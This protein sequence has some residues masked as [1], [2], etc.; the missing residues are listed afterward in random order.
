M[1]HIEVES[2]DKCITTC[3]PW[4]YKINFIFFGEKNLCQ[5]KEK[6]L[7]IKGGTKNGRKKNGKT[8]PAG[9]MIVLAAPGGKCRNWKQQRRGW[10]KKR[11]GRKFSLLDSFLSLPNVLSLYYYY[12]YY[13]RSSI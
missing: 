3:G 11:H 9:R 1:G 12:Y 6:K 2:C 13:L 4:T 7:D 8:L 5:K 10:G